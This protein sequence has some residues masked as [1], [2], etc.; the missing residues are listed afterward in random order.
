MIT[1]I[2]CYYITGFSHGL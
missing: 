2:K 1:M